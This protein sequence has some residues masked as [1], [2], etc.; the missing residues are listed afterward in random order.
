MSFP[1]SDRPITAGQVT[2]A[3]SVRVNPIIPGSMTDAL[4]DEFCG[5]LCGCVQRNQRVMQEGD[6]DAS[7]EEA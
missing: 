1:T 2:I 7:V 4:V 6:A 5:A 3:P